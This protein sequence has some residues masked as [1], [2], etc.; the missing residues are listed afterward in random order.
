MVRIALGFSHG[1]VITVTFG[2]HLGGPTEFDNPIRIGQ[3]H[4][5]VAPI[6]VVNKFG[7]V[8]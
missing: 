7:E 4:G 8:V 3:R 2:P 5:V 1:I 6:G